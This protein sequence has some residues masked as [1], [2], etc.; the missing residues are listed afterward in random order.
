MKGIYQ[1]NKYANEFVL[2]FLNPTYLGG[3]E[4]PP[5]TKYHHMLKLLKNL[6][7]SNKIISW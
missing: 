1:A 3:K 7:V 5:F 4:S 6:M 2:N